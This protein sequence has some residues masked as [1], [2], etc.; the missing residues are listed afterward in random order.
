MKKKFINGFF[1][2]ALLFVAVGSFVSCKDTDEDAIA[3]LRG[4]LQRQNATLEELIKAQVAT[5]EGKITNLEN[6][7]A[8]CEKECN[9]IKTRLDAVENTIKNTKHLTKEEADSY[10]V[11]IEVYTRKIAE[12]EAAI[13]K[14]DGV[15]DAINSLKEMDK[16]LQGNIDALE[17][18]LTGMISDVNKIATQAAADA[19]EA[20]RLAT[21]N[22]VDIT[23]IKDDISDIKTTIIGWGERL[24]QVK[25]D[26]A[27]AQATADAAQ[28]AADRVLELLNEHIANCGGSTP[29]DIQNQ[30]D[31]INRQINELKGLLSNVGNNQVASEK[32]VDDA[33]SA[34]QGNTTTTLAG[35]E[36]RFN[37]F[38]TDNGDRLTQIENDINAL[39]AAIDGLSKN[40]QDLVTGIIVQ[41]T[42]NP[43]IGYMNMPLD[44]RSTM[45][46]AFC[47][48]ETNGFDVI[49]PT[50]DPNSYIGAGAAQ[51][52]QAL[53]IE[54]IE[55]LW[56]SWE[57]YK[58]NVLQ[59]I[60]SA[61][62]RIFDF[63]PGKKEQ[64]AYAG[65]LYVT[66]NPNTVDFSGQTL[67][68]E[69]SAAEKSAMTLSP[70]QPSDFRL[71]FG[72][73]KAGNDNGFYEA[74]AYVKENDVTKLRARVD[75]G[76]LK[77][78][79]K[80]LL[81]N[82]NGIDLTQLVTTIYT[83]FSDVLD[84]NAVKASYNSYVYENGVPTKSVT[85][86]VFSN[87]NL[88]LTSIKPLSYEFS[89]D[90]L[91]MG[92]L[93]RR[94]ATIND[95]VIIFDD[96][97]NIDINLEGVET[98]IP[99]SGKVP[100]QTISDGHGGTI[101]IPETTFNT[102]AD[103]TEF[104]NSL[105]ST[106][107]GQMNTEVQDMITTLQNQVNGKINS[108]ISQANNVVNKVNSVLD[109]FENF[110]KTIDSKLQ[111]TMFFSDASGNY[112]KAS[113]AWLVPTKLQMSGSGDNAVKL[114]AT[115]YTA[116][117]LAPACKKL[118]CVS[119]VVR[120]DNNGNKHTAQNGDEQC[121]Y[122]LEYANGKGLLGGV[123]SGTVRDFAL[124]TKGEYA[125]Y[126]YEVSYF[127]LDFSGVQ[128]RTKYYIQPVR[129]Y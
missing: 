108:Y 85:H 32:Y 101:T 52:A 96:D 34:I 118:V 12:L 27:A 98:T 61:G 111:P 8:A 9:D 25:L 110:V 80:D 65:T 43:M 79:A 59:N 30:L 68:L 23:N 74:K 28:Q 112:H 81:D 20:L 49:F 60:A 93:S 124:V 31:E 11:Q 125:N 119:N 86:S 17:S 22:G 3:E 10:Y 51:D 63:E 77:D 45:L 47:G 48:E 64:G 94:F 42:I 107:S 57:K 40:I 91:P 114:T 127:A 13:A 38:N 4:E 15:L 24:T 115:S 29:V 16:T 62:G 123:V 106:I 82:K 100:S 66:V 92:L 113:E 128:S 53:T 75:F 78:V 97:I 71:S 2:V 109:S 116:E 67:T 83:S 120:Y 87:Y 26:A 88:A 89:T 55:L 99:V 14:L 7:K 84:A 117:L 126:I 69:N 70:L 39:K 5:L 18:K 105:T 121:K 33:I 6:A 58:S 102:T 46:A 72:W 56:G 76:A 21:A 19:T 54:E 73:T 103:L 90:G 95:I 104:L 50:D 41:G 44:M 35:L 37:D 1:M 36:Q 122:A 129:E